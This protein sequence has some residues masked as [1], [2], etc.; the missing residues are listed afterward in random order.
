[1]LATCAALALIGSGCGDGGDDPGADP[2]FEALRRVNDASR[3]LGVRYTLRVRLSDGDTE[4]IT[5]RGYGQVQADAQRVRTVIVAG[6]ERIETFTD[7]PFEL[8]PIDPSIGRRLDNVIPAGTKWIKVDQDKLA[9]ASGLADLRRLQNQTPG[10]ALDL[11][12]KLKPKIEDAGPE[13]VDGLMTKRYRATTTFAAILKVIADE[14]KALPG[15][16]DTIGDATLSYVFW[17]DDDDLV[18]RFRMRLELPGKLANVVTLTVT[19]YDRTLRVQVPDE[20][21]VYDATDELAEL[22]RKG[23]GNED[24]LPDENTRLISSTSP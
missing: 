6:D 24:C 23:K 9:E 5:L 18:R 2:L 1:M 19:K 7:E 13:R 20:S 21:I 8:S 10:E 22:A 17:I 12:K 15:C 4:T 16:L 3:E 14:D 11:L